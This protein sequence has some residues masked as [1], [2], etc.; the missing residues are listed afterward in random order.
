MA[1]EIDIVGNFTG[2]KAFKEADSAISVLTKS[3]AKLAGTLGVVRL[4]QK[5]V[6]DF[7]ADEKGTKIL[8]Q[9]LKNVGLAY[10]QTGAEDFIAK[11]QQQT[12]I[13]DDELR[14]AYA[15]L[16]RVTGSVLETQ[17]LMATAFDVSRGT[18]QDYASVIDA[19]SQAYVGNTKGLKSLNIGLTQAELKGKSF[20][21]I[22]QILNGQFAGAGA[23]S[24]D[25][26]AG[27]MD[28]LR[29]NA[30][31]ASEAIGKS[32][33]DALSTAAGSGGFP[34]FIGQVN[35][36]VTALSDL[37]TGLG[38][39][40][41]LVRAVASPSK[42]FG[43]IANRIS[44][45][46]AQ[47]KSEDIQIMKERAGI[48]NNFSS[49]QGYAANQALTS[50]AAKKA[51]ADAKKRAA[52]LLAQQKQQNKLATTNL[53]LQ[54]AAAVFDMKKIQIT[55]ALK[56]AKD[57]ETVTRLKLMLAIENEQGDLAE[58]LQ[59][60]LDII[61]AKNKELQGFLDDVQGKTNTVKSSLGEVA[62]LKINPFD[63]TGIY[64]GISDLDLLKAK[65]TELTGVFLDNQIAM[66]SFSIGIAQ[67]LSTAAA[68]SGARYAAQGAYQTGVNPTLNPTLTPTVPTTP[69][70]PTTVV[71]NNVTVNGAIDPVSTARTIDDLLRQSAGISGDI[72]D[73]GFNWISALG[74]TP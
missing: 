36:G 13:L 45:M 37:I 44:A 41:A 3:A 22:V 6:F 38:R 9:N 63:F 46:R 27:K 32:L 40:I 62:T 65:V 47:W 42:G 30:A 68:I 60:K 50:A 53:K 34:A 56:S 69:T 61:I 12:G 2:K 26:Y 28:L 43:D 24:L 10:A 74:A 71:N 72:R 39:T 7:M 4:A 1:V 57:E 21:E 49:H 14:P 5:A 18:G 31:N 16:A 59:K 51:E 48:A 67:G 15:Q 33:L 52:A 55:A 23:A 11:L 17:K 54:K 73:V 64:K 20:N 25:S 70:T 66:G 19:L 29:V 58:A 8:A 35:T